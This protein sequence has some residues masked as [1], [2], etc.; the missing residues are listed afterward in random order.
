VSG[1]DALVKLQADLLAL[2]RA[3]K[4]VEG[5]R[6]NRRAILEQAKRIGTS[7]FSELRPAIEG[8][9]VAKE[10]LD[11][12][13]KASNA[14]SRSAARTTSRPATS[15]RLADSPRSSRRTCSCRSR[16]RRL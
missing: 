15:T 6:I 5:D 11:R 14:S 9:V 12:Y 2:S 3:V 8:S 1:A 7:W 16:P 10:V 13:G 4:A